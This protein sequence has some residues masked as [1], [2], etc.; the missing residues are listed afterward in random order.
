LPISLWGG[1]GVLAACAAV[2]FAGGFV[3]RLRG[4]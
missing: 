4:G 2:L 1:F 3:F